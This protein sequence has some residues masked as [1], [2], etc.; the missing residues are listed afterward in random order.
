MGAVMTNQLIFLGTGQR[1]LIVVKNLFISYFLKEGDLLFL[2]IFLVHKR[3]AGQ[4][5]L[6]VHAATQE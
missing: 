6:P 5:K 3:N 2:R 1:K 4:M